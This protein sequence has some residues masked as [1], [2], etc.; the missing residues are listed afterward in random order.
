MIAAGKEKGYLTY[1]EVSDLLPYHIVDPEQVEDIIGMINDM[2]IDVYEEPPDEDA[3]NPYPMKR[4][5]MKMKWP[6]K[7]P[8]HLLSRLTGIWSDDRSRS[9]VYARDGDCRA[10]NATRRN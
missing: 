5:L 8:K 4:L 6:A 1:A 3:L 7:L 10:I 2:G 9:Y